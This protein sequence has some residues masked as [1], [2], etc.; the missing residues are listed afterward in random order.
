MSDR[1]SI[2][3]NGTVHELAV[4]GEMPLLW[5]IRDVAG[6]T[7]TKYGCGVGV[8]G[9]CTVL[10]DGAATRSCSVSVSDVA[11]SRVVT[12]EHLGKAGLHPVQEAWVQHNVPQC[13]YCQSGFI[14]QIVDLLTNS[15]DLSDEDL[16]ASLTNICR[17]GTYPRMP[18]AIA[19]A[20]KL[21]QKRGA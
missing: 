1:F 4:P 14:M 5:A 18:E 7:G 8:C 2:E 13:G 12:I 11:Q 9:A 19:E 15:P 3:I 16:L 6:L 17:C 20:R 10:V 21:M